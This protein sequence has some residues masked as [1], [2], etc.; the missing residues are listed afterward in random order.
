M[1][2][3]F[4]SRK[5]EI[6]MLDMNYYDGLSI[7]YNVECVNDR[8]KVYAHVTSED[9]AVDS[10][11]KTA[12]VL[13]CAWSVYNEMYP[14]SNSKNH[15][16]LLTTNLEDAVDLLQLQDRYSEFVLGVLHKYI[17]KRLRKEFLNDNQRNEK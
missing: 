16:W 11:I 14:Y 9:F 15:C 5:V 2:K 4:P 8:V 12:D 13:S 6:I 7:V 3:P 17:S 10:I 1:V